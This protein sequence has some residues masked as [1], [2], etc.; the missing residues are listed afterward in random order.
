M[1]AR[2][3]D[4]A[5]LLGQ[6][7]DLLGGCGGHRRLLDGFGDVA[8]SADGFRVL[9]RNQDLQ[10]RSR[11]RGRHGKD[12]LGILHDG[13]LTRSVLGQTA[14]GQLGLLAAAGLLGLPAALLFLAL[15]ALLILLV[16]K[17]ARLLLG[18]HGLRL[19]AAAALVVGTDR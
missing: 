6:V 16:G 9:V 1:R 10:L 8:A 11:D 14:G 15:L 17:P 13:V 2:L 4:R 19:G 7:S 5:F 18:A 12:F 3:L